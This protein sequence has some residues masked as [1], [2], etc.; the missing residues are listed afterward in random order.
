MA[1]ALAGAWL[2][3]GPG[4]DE[5]T[6]GPDGGTI[7]KDGVEIEFPA[8]AVEDEA[9]VE[10]EQVTADAADG[11]SDLENRSE[12]F[13]VELSEP[14][15]K[16]VTLT[17]PADAEAGERGLLLASRE[18]DDEAWLLAPARGGDGSVS[19]KTFHLSFWQAVK[20]TAG[21]VG[22]ELLEAAGGASAEFLRLGGV[23]AREP[24]CASPP[25]GM[26]LDG[27]PGIGD[28]NALI[29]A[30][31]EGRDGDS[32]LKIVNNRAIGMETEPP[33]AFRVEDLDSA[34]VDDVALDSLR[35]LAGGSWLTIPSTGS[36]A[37]TAEA[38]TEATIEVQ[39]TLR[40]FILDMAVFVV[41]QVGGKEGA[42]IGAINSYLECTA[43][44]ANA[45]GDG[46]PASASDALETAQ[47][48]ARGCIDTL[49]DVS[50]G[51]IASVSKYLA[52]FY[53]GMKLGVGLADAIAELI[54]GQR[55]TLGLKRAQV[56][57][58]RD[59]SLDTVTGEALITKVRANVPCDQ[60]E[61]L[62][63]EILQR[64][65]CVEETPG[66][67]QSCEAQS[68]QCEIPIEY[69]PERFLI[70]AGCDQG[71]AHIEFEHGAARF[72]AKD[73]TLTFGSDGRPDAIGPFDIE[74]GDSTIA[75]AIDAF[76]EPTLITE[77]N[78]LTCEVTWQELGLKGVFVNFGD[79]YD[80]CRS[81]FLDHAVIRAPV[82]HTAEGLAVGDTEAELQDKHPSATT[83]STGPAIPYFD[84]VKNPGDAFYSVET[85]YSEIGDAGIRPSL[86]A[87]IE[88]DEVTGLQVNAGLGGD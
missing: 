37:L 32:Q 43:E 62:A 84:G 28:A 64:D 55:A 76:G 69:A 61:S 65:D 58:C 88:G 59:A 60:A 44:A 17:L 4:G 68:Y 73:Y 56:V 19:V 11:Y 23:R 54:Q 79:T 25:L 67:L 72:S 8:G 40:A 12:G 9:E 70:K 27:N 42:A 50:T 6:I 13:S 33:D 80:I 20:D 5:L 81:A 31:L 35:N 49:G 74:G 46:V 22:L 77:A 87:L 15:L 26:S 30:C 29:F 39:P 45:V 63:S 66:N 52:V 34:Q 75:D 2:L 1:Q 24:S 83:R 53:G 78:S 10:I 7:S 18:S 47:S 48:V 71:A 57:D 16:P 21:A 51:A 3:L 38:G 85:F 14:L 86:A 82:F 41:G 36:V